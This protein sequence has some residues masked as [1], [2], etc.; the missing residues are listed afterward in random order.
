MTE[1]PILSCCVS[2]ELKA[3]VEEISARRRWSRSQTMAWLLDR[4]V[5]QLDLEEAERRPREVRVTTG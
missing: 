5:T 4:A 3:A 2:H 1:S